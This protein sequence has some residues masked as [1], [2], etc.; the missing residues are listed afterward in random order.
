[1]ESV[2]EQF[3]AEKV[4]LIPFMLVAG[5]HALNDLA[6]ADPGSWKSRLEKQGCKC[7]CIL[8]GLG[9]IPAV[10]ACFADSLPGKG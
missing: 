3:R 10:A 5:D 8:H 1:M 9:E 7:D 4:L 6:G 2:Q